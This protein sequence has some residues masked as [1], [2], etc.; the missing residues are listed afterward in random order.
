[1]LMK[2]PVTEGDILAGKYRV[3]RVLGAGGMGVVVSATDE[4]LERRVAIKFLL[5]EYAQHHEASERFLREA[6]AAVKIQSEHVARVIDVG[7]MDTGA[8][9]IVMEY[10]EGADLAEVLERQGALPVEEACRHV[11]EA[12]DAIAEAHAK[13]IIHRD[14][15]PANLFLARQPDG[16]S[17]VKILDFG[18]SKS[19]IAGQDMSLTRT[20][21]LMG[22][23]LYMSP[24][25]MRSSRDVDSRT[26][27]WSLGVILYELL[28]GRP[29]FD[30]QSVPELSAKVLLDHPSPVSSARPELPPELDAVFKQVLAKD[31]SDRYA[32][33]GDFAMDVL[34]FGPRRAKANVERIARTLREAGL[35]KR[36]L[37][38]PMTDPP[39]ALLDATAMAN[40][41]PTIREPRVA[42]ETDETMPSA[43]MTVRT[44][45]SWGRTNGPAIE[46]PP[47]SVKRGRGLVVGLGLS[48]VL[49]AGGV[50]AALVLRPDSEEAP[51]EAPTVA[52]VMEESAV[53]LGEPK[54]VDLEAAEPEAEP[55]PSAADDAA[56]G[57]EVDAPPP[58]SSP[59]KPAA[60]PTAK[61]TTVPVRRPA[62]K[63]APKP[64]PKTS[65][66]TAESKPSLKDRFGTRK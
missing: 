16:T 15:K 46:G 39:P 44:E 3:D 31:P 59:P 23:P 13:G 58:A 9:Y 61:A 12:C 65:T 36:V 63:P 14:L 11:L 26:D 19:T 49:V 20:S 29:P 33:V 2:A 1:M 24:E 60:A 7:T 38:L 50:V 47:S 18:I 52:A 55:E 41:V 64:A 43:G 17:K 35:S 10:L 42:Q 53:P 21:A 40:Q 51:E 62:A 48:G 22:S 66:P 34:P 25:Q 28:T 56:S 6:R 37:T 54:A 45:A 8:P 4:Q 32:T 30:A 5:P 57:S 27:I